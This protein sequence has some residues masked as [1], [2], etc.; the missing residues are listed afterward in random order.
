MKRRAFLAAGATGTLA[1]TAGCLGL[2]GSSS[3]IKHPGNLDTSFHANKPLP[4]DDDPSDGIPPARDDPPEERSF[5]PSQFPT[6]TTNGEQITLAPI[7]VA[8]Y[9][10]QRGEARFVDARGL[11]Y[12]KQAHVYG[13]VSSTAERGSTGGGISGWPK[14]DRVVCYCGCPHHLSSIRASA[15]QQNGFSNVYVIDEGFVPWRDNGYA[16]RGTSFAAPQ[17]AVI[18]GAVDASYAGEYAW[19]THE[20]TGQSEA[21]PI[22]DDGSFEVH[23]KFYGLGADAPIHVQTPAFE[24][25][26]PLSELTGTVLTP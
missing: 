10:H 4:S 16:M 9:W 13:A 25:T 5:D 23:F 11:K 8:R 14:D 3:D 6:T 24:V 20:P 12:Y 18:E 21:A 2:F 17:E 26:K 19:A 22:G 15:L 1:A 7:D